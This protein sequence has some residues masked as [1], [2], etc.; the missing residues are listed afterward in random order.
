MTLDMTRFIK[1]GVERLHSG[2]ACRL[3]G[4]S[5]CRVAPWVALLALGWVVYSR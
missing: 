1:V 2:L 4:F 3:H 5:L